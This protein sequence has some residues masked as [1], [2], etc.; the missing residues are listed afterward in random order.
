MRCTVSLFI[1]ILVFD[2]RGLD[3]A[4]RIIGGSYVDVEELPYVARLRHFVVIDAEDQHTE[5]DENLCSC[6]IL[7]PLW[8]LTAAHCFIE[9]DVYVQKVQKYKQL[10]IPYSI[11]A[12]HKVSYGP[13]ENNTKSVIQY[14][15]HPAYAHNQFM[16]TNDIALVKTRPI[17]L[18]IYGFLSAVDYKIVVGHRAIVAGYGSRY[19]PGPVG[20]T[21]N[22]SH[23]PEMPLMKLEV[24]VVNCHDNS[25]VKPSMCIARR[26]GR[27]SHL[28][29]GDSGGPLIH[30]SGIIGINSMG[31]KDLQNFCVLKSKLPVFDVG[32]M[33][34]V[35][36]F[37][38]WISRIIETQAT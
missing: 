8:T 37:I 30:P 27:P 33:T 19:I 23:S 28:C 14:F 22:F 38:D 20:N 6:A 11:S 36:P 7:T 18:N 32:I 5:E 16:L 12:G 25:R 34:P 2:I 26:C 21:M 17:F 9:F 15:Q 3:S 1:A 29:V 4:L 35:S 13:L 31:P 10:G 24:V